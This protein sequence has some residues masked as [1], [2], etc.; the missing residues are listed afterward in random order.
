M[1]GWPVLRLFLSVSLS[2]S[3]SLA[4]H[5]LGQT[6]THTRGLAVYFPSILLYDKTE[7]ISCYRWL[8]IRT[9]HS[10][11]L[12]FEPRFPRLLPKPP[13]TSGHGN[14]SPRVRVTRTRGSSAAS[15]TRDP[16]NIGY[17]TFSHRGPDYPP[18]VEISSWF[19]PGAP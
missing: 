17:A 4:L 18:L 6:G 16:G 1:R 13:Q 5:S 19:S 10:R 2:L 7:A 14:S 3:S 11:P 12:V 8:N 15:R 9:S